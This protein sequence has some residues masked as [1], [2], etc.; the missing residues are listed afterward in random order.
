MAIEI[1]PALSQDLPEI[2]QI[3]KTSFPYGIPLHRKPTHPMLDARIEEVITDLMC[4][5]AECSD[6]KII[7]AENRETAE[8]AGYLILTLDGKDFFTGESQGFIQDLAVKR[9]YW[10]KF[11]AQRLVKQACKMAKDRGLKYMVAIVSADNERSMVLGTK[12]LDFSIERYQIV[13]RLSPDRRQEMS[14]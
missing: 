4:V 5:H 3:A 8:I 9:R 11:V 2:Q 12:G 1:R 14:G 10:G 13:K 7:V 6:L